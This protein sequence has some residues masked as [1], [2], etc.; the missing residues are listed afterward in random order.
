MHL[1]YPQ[2][3]IPERGIWG[4]FFLSFLFCIEICLINNVL[5]FSGEQQRDSDTHIYG[6]I[7]PKLPSHPSRHITLKTV[8]CAVWWVFVG[9]LF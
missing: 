9:Y 3:C 6:S 7:L 2:K 1:S 8:P 5:T 4:F